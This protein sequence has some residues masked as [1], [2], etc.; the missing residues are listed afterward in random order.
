MKKTFS[1]LLLLLV[2]IFN[3]FSAGAKN[4]E[5]ELSYDIKCAGTPQQ[6]YYLVEVTA[7]VTKKM[8][9]NMDVIRKS[10]VHGV[11]FS[12]FSGEQGCKAQ[13]PMLNATQELQ[14]SDFF[15]AFFERDCLRFVNAVDKTFSTTKVGKKYALTATVQVAKEELRKT[16]ENAGIIRK[17]GF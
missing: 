17:L 16:L 11:I 10:A 6:G 15:E 2:M 13:R 4:S 9:I 12:G 5:N 3:S 8:D 1:L 14:H 7:Y